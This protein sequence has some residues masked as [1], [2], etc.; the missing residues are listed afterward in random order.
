MT[1]EV[2]E[3][4]KHLSQLEMKVM[5]VYQLEMAAL[6][7][8]MSQLKKDILVF[9]LQKQINSLRNE[10]VSSKVL[11]LKRQI[12]DKKIKLSSKKEESRGFN[13]ELTSKYELE[14]KWGYDPDTGKILKED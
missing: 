1:D 13:K 10:L 9:E 11:E 7:S 6:D 12:S 3:N 8:E 2:V 14:S 5:E 4:D